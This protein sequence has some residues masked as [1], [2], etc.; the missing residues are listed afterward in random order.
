MTIK[1]A[2][3]DAGMTQNQLSELSGVNIRTIQKIESGE[4]NVR[5]IANATVKSLADALGIDASEITEYDI[6]AGTGAR[7]LRMHDVLTEEA[8]KGLT[9]SQRR[10]LLKGEQARE[11]SGLRAYPTTCSRVFARIPDE[12]WDMYSAKHIGEVAKLL[13]AA[14]DDGRCNPSPDEYK[15][16]Y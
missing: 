15:K 1:T 9:A 10:M 2:R 7:I 13:K 8:F 14:Y 4:S 6:D 11:Y 5:N 3:K 12:W 16:I